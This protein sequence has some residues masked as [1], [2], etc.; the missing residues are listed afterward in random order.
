MSSLLSKSRIDFT[1][2]KADF[3]KIEK[4]IIEEKESVSH[5]IVEFKVDNRIKFLKIE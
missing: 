1:S 2:I 3:Q 5:Q 4:D